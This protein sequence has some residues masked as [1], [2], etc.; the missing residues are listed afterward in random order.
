MLRSVFVSLTLGA[1]SA[2]ASGFQP[3]RTDM[4]A[5]N[6]GS[7]QS[8]RQTPNQP[9]PPKIEQVQGNPTLSPNEQP[10]FD[11]QRGMRDEGNWPMTPMTPPADEDRNLNPPSAPFPDE[12]PLTPV[13]PA[14][15]EL[16]V[17]PVMPPSDP[18]CPVLL[19]PE[20]PLIDDHERIMGH[21]DGY[22]RQ[23]DFRR[24]DD[25]PWGWHYR[26]MD[27]RGDGRGWGRG[28]GDDGYRRYRDID[29]RGYG[30]PYRGEGRSGRGERLI[31]PLAL[32]TAPGLAAT[33]DD[34]TP[35]NGCHDLYQRTDHRDWD[36][37]HYY[38]G[39]RDRFRYWRCDAE[40]YCYREWGPRP[41]GER[42]EEEEHEHE[43][44]ALPVTP[45]L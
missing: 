10:G 35:M 21:G 22:Y 19:L 5:C 8:D 45:P 15:P 39:D 38:R 26:D 29:D 7:S 28:Y 23:T 24:D 42:H 20:C 17:A 12:Q 41:W 36:D 25:R 3:Q 31:V 18:T 2:L 9:A 14:K 37:D 32:V 11:P 1:L 6:S 44:I 13:P 43:H 30:Y 33:P 40:G 4:C 34:K 16:V 27:R